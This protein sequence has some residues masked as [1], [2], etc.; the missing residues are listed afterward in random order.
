MHPTQGT[1]P[2]YL[3]TIVE[4]HRA[5]LHGTALFRG[6]EDIESG[7]VSCVRVATSTAGGLRSG[8]ER[9]ARAPS[10]GTDETPAK[11]W[12]FGLRKGLAFGIRKDLS[13][14]GRSSGAQ[15]TV[16]VRAK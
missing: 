11:G 9:K 13:F 16:F 3:S 12:T 5:A 15:P 8:R 7:A 4:D 6:N 10:R 14:E 2:H 1:K